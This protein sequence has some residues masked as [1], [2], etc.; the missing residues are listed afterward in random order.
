M[1]ITTANHK[2]TTNPARTFYKKGSTSTPILDKMTGTVAA[3]TTSG[4]ESTSAMQ[5]SFPTLTSTQASEVVF[6]TDAI[7]GTATTSP[8]AKVAGSVVTYLFSITA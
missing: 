6:F 4:M 1:V 8:F 5:V 2:V 7:V 3:G